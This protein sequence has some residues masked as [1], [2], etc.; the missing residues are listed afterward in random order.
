MCGREEK[1]RE[2]SDRRTEGKGL[3]RRPSCGWDL[4]LKAYFKQEFWERYKFHF[5]KLRLKKN[6]RV[7]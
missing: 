4:N 6:G 5:L 1:L 2:N 7:F 3:F